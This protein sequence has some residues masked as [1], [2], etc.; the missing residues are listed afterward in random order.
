MKRTTFF[1][2]LGGLA[3]LPF[4]PKIKK[5]EPHKSGDGDYIF[6]PEVRDELIDRQFI[7]TRIFTQ[8]KIEFFQAQAELERSLLAEIARCVD[9]QILAL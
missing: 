5:E 8:Q 6:P 4:L 3:L 7:K 1:K 2:A 9:K